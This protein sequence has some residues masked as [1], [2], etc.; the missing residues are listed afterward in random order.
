MSESM[1]E[2]DNPATCHPGLPPTTCIGKVVSGV[3]PTAN[4]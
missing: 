4:R 3:F 1:P 2:S